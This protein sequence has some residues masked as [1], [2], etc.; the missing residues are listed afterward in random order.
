[1]LAVALAWP[2]AA[3][4]Q[5]APSLPSCG[6]IGVRVHPMT[7]AFAKSLGM[8]APY[9]AIF[10][11]PRPGSPAA[12][13]GIQRYD[14]VTAIEGATLQSWRDFAPAIAKTAPGTRIHLTT[15]RNGQLMDVRVR[16]RSGSCDARR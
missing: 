13:A 16:V 8:T 5:P 15:Q 2:L 9:G 3:R 12:G 6:W 7:E 14:V 11:Q 10:G 1:L 4:A